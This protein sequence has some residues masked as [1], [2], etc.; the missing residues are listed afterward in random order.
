MAQLKAT[1]VSKQE[2]W[3]ARKAAREAWL[4]AKQA[5]R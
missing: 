5:Q 1:L 3:E 4:A 2:E